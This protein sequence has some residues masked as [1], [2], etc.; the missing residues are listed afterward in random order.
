MAQNYHKLHLKVSELKVW[1]KPVDV[2]ENIKTVP[3]TRKPIISISSDDFLFHALNVSLLLAAVQLCNVLVLRSYYMKYFNFGNVS[4]LCKTN[5][6]SFCLIIKLSHAMDGLFSVL[7]YSRKKTNRRGWGYT[8]LKL[9]LLEI[10]YLWLY[11]RNSA[12][13]KLLPLEIL[14]NCV[15]PLGNSKVKNQ[16]PW[17]LQMSFSWIPLEIPLLF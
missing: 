15:T 4:V 6:S 5:R 3:A 16:D 9:L 7:G 1:V 11:L 12:E 13:N 2:F 8:F 17:E 10:L 14:Q